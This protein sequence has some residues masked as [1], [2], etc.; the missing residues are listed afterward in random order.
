MTQP[1][2][3]LY[4]GVIIAYE[5]HSH[6]LVELLTYRLRDR[7]TMTHYVHPTEI[8]FHK[9]H[10][11]FIVMSARDLSQLVNFY[12]RKSYPLPLIVHI[13]VPEVFEQT[14]YAH[15]FPG[16]EIVTISQAM[17]TENPEDTLKITLFREIIEHL[18]AAAA[19]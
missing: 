19:G 13:D 5:R 10:H 9:P 18:E 15:Q 14:D 1:H 17:L 2:H 7:L 11:F 6:A 16:V 4:G 3:K 8:D 12:D